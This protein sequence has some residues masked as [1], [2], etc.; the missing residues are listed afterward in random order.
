MKARPRLWLVL[1]VAGAM[2]IAACGG[3]SDLDANAGSDFSVV[4]GEAPVFDGCDSVGDIENYEWLITSAPASRA[5]DVGKALRATMDDCSFELESA[6]LVDDV[7][8]WTIE[9]TVTSGSDT[10]TDAVTVEVTE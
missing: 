3:G 2:L 7:G 6:M 9:L 1:A 5:D 4:V 10:A 8:D